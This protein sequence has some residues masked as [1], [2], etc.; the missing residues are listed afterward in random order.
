VVRKPNRVDDSDYDP[1]P[2]T[3]ERFAA[4]FPAGI[5]AMHPEFNTDDTT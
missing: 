5:A 4:A 2:L 3:D 1:T